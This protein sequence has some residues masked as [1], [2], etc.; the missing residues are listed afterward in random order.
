MREFTN[1][2]WPEEPFGADLRPFG[3]PT[4]MVAAFAVDWA[5][6]GRPAAAAVAYL[7]GKRAGTVEVSAATLNP[8][9]VAVVPETDGDVG[10][11]A[12]WFDRA[13]VRARVKAHLLA[14]HDLQDTLTPMKKLVDVPMAGV[15]GVANCWADRPA[16]ARTAKVARMLDTALDL[17]DPLEAAARLGTTILGPVEPII[18]PR[19][20]HEQSH[21]AFR[22]AA[23][24][25]AIGL[26]AARH[27][28]SYRW[29]DELNVPTA[30]AH[31]AWDIFDLDPVAAVG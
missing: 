17:P 31:A 29:A 19:G 12:D 21:T 25:L 16:T 3:N 1:L 28:G 15:T 23:R 8:G 24:A 10:A 22:C 14:G 27:T 5:T 13:L 4:P 2:L 9:F 7:R 11:I 6:D 18:W 26:A 30:L 20:T